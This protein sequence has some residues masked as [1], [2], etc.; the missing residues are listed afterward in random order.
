[1]RKVFLL[2]ALGLVS[3]AASAQTVIEL[4]APPSDVEEK[5]TYKPNGDVDTYSSVTRPSM[6]VCLPDASIA[7]GASML[8]FPGGGLM[9]LSWDG[10]FMQIAKYLNARGVAAIGV[11]YRT[12]VMNPSAMRFPANGQN[13]GS[14]PAAPQGQMAQR[15]PR[16][17]FS[18][19][20]NFGVIEKANAS[21]GG[22]GDDPTLNNAA[23]D[24]FNA[25][26]L[27]K[28]HASEWGIDPARIGVM[29]FSAGGG[30]EIAALMRYETFRPAYMCS[31]Y[32]PS[33]MDVEVPA[34]APKLYIAVKAD[35]HNVAAGCLALFLEWK[36]AGI[37]AEMHVYGD[38]TGSLWGNGAKPTKGEPTANGHW[39]E[40][41][42]S[43]MTANCFTTEV[44]A[45]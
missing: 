20:Q 31:V 18:V 28:A 25:M 42:Y 3:V 34:D 10:E 19:I 29:G 14:R 13:T 21:P 41:F 7:T 32:G 33:L 17:D 6:T 4:P 15:A 5:V 36:K 39:L 2:A 45:D 16:P 38:G 43:W 11:K 40:T 9:S 30:V 35:H 22:G 8:I 26:E 27:V 44:K 23:E 24:A 1:M 37:D 12:R